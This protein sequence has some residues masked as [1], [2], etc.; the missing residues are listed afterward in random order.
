MEVDMSV[1]NTITS[2]VWN[3]L[4]S[5]PRLETLNKCL[6]TCTGERLQVCGIANVEVKCNGQV[7]TLPITVIRG[8]GS[9]FMGRDWLS[10]LKL[11]WPEMIGRIGAAHTEKVRGKSK[12]ND[13][14]EKHSE[15][16]LRL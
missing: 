2:E 1:S 9:S 12:L 14:L 10:V 3:K 5:R 11:N 4:H 8:A 7:K 16:F 6:I 15:V 13:L